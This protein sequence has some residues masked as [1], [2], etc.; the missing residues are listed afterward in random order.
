MKNLTV[1]VWLHEQYLLRSF[2]LLQQQQETDEEKV[3]YEIGE[4]SLQKWGLYDTLNCN[5]SKSNQK[6]FVKAFEHP[7]EN[8]I[9]VFHRSSLP[10]DQLYVYEYRLS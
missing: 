7:A 6:I 3:K 2:T 1:C 8:K 10:F 4:M 9:Y 5:Y